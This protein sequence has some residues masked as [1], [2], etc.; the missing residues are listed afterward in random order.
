LAWHFFCPPRECLDGIKQELINIPVN[1]I[2]IEAETLEPGKMT[3]L[4]EEFPYKKAILFVEEGITNGF[5]KQAQQTCD[6]RG[7]QLLFMKGGNREQEIKEL[8]VKA[9]DF[10]YHQRF[11]PCLG[12]QVAVDCGGEIKPCLWMDE[13]VGTVGCDNLKNLIISGAFDKYWCLTKDYISVCK[14]CEKRYACSDCRIGAKPGTGNELNDGK[15]AFCSY[16]PYT[17]GN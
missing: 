11:N 3:L 15:P 1:I 10:Y 8:K 7:A 12:R 17:G 6:S 4:L 5:K 9:Y 16:D 2:R 13:P 14:D